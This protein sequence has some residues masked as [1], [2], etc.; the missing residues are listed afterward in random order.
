MFV[1]GI[2]CTHK[3]RGAGDATQGVACHV[4]CCAKSAANHRSVNVPSA[5]MTA[6]NRRCRSH[7]ASHLFVF[8]NPQ[9]HYHARHPDNTSRP[10]HPVRRW[11]L[12]RLQRIKCINLVAWSRAE[13]HPIRPLFELSTA[14]ECPPPCSSPPSV[15]TIREHHG[16]RHALYC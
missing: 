12:C 10:L 11:H 15:V 2:K 3:I 13:W 1:R 5:K 4:W 16:R 8:P 7:A 9:Q 6:L 14:C